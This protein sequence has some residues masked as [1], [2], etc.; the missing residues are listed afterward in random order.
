MNLIWHSLFRHSNLNDHLYTVVLFRFL[1]CMIDDESCP[2]WHRSHRIPHLHSLCS[3]DMLYLSNFKRTLARPNLPQ[4]TVSCSR[5]ALSVWMSSSELINQLQRLVSNSCRGQLRV[6]TYREVAVSFPF[7]LSLNEL[8]CILIP[9]FIISSFWKLHFWVTLWF[10]HFSDSCYWLQSPVFSDS[11]YLH[12]SPTS[13]WLFI[14]P[15][16]LQ[17]LSKFSEI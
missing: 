1:S 15:T 9:S 7:T 11:C 6:L 17:I 8:K 2:C 13:L 16:R 4:Y 10:H 12:H 3:R 14:F 5:S